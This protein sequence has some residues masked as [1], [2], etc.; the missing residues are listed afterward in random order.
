MWKPGPQHPGTL[1]HGSPAMYTP[2]PAAHI[3][4]FW[5]PGES[6]D[7]GEAEPSK[8]AS[9]GWPGRGQPGICRTLSHMAHLPVLCVCVPVLSPARRMQ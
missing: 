3:V 1:V 9:R 8:R 7:L 5:A 4:L 6:L 2:S